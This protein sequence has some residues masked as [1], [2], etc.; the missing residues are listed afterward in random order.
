MKQYALRL[1]KEDGMQYAIG[2]FCLIVYAGALF[3]PLMDK[4]AAHHANIALHML[5]FNDYTSLVDRNTDYLDK[6]HFL[7]WMS[8][9]SFKIFGVNTFAYRLPAM[10]C[11][12]VAVGSTYKLARH[13]SDKTTAKLAAIMLAT[14]QGFILSINDARME[15]PLAAA[16][17]FGLWN[18][19]VFIDKK[20]LVSILFAALGAAIA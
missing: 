20:R 17:I 13:L 11:A 2:L 3:F 15:T 16:I 14:A 9:L 8:A 4:D 1:Q 19:I 6:P 7:F 12:L 5:Q 10:L 18:L